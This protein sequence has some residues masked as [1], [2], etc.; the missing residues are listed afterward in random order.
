MGYS[1]AWEQRECTVRYTDRVTF[2]DL[3]AAVKAIHADPDFSVLKRV[4]H[5]VSEA[6]EVDDSDVDLS[7]L[8]SHELGA[9]FTNPNLLIAVVSDRPDIAQLAKC[10]NAL[11]RLEIPVFPD[12]TAAQQWRMQNHTPRPDMHT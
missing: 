9:R 4:V 7:A 1:I 12:R 11:T 5:D 10:F 3:L 8:A 2:S 6:V